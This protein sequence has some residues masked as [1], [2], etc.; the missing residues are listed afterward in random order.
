MSL[1][2][3]SSFDPLP[4][5]SA[6][7]PETVLGPERP[8]E[9]ADEPIEPSDSGGISEPVHQLRDPGSFREDG[10]DYLLYSVAGERG[11]AIAEIM[12]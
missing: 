8:W 11:I 4:E 9:G 7:A 3:I 6:S 5:W 12:D 10:R 1:L 2:G